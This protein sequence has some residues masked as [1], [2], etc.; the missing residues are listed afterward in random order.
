M[1]KYVTLGLSE[2]KPNQTFA[3]K[4]EQNLAAYA[5]KEAE[6]FACDAAAAALAGFPVCG[7]IKFFASMTSGFWDLA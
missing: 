4:E 6:G 2:S 7:T 3:Q 1:G 5:K